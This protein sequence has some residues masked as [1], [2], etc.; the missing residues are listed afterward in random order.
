MTNNLRHGPFFQGA[1]MLKLYHHIILKAYWNLHIQISDRLIWWYI[2][3]LLNLF[4]GTI[5]KTHKNTFHYIKHSLFLSQTVLSISIAILFGIWLFPKIYSILKERKYA[6]TVCVDIL[7]EHA[8]SYI[9]INTHIYS[10]FMR[11][12]P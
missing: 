6:P 11:A 10:D 12:I 7:Y 5:Y 9:Y 1:Y 4:W 3:L 2:Y 8:H